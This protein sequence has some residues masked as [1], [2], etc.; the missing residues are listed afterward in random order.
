MNHKYTVMK[1]IT[2]RSCICGMPM[3]RLHERRKIDGKWTYIHV[4]WYC[5]ICHSVTLLYDERS[6]SCDGFKT[7]RLVVTQGKVMQAIPKEHTTK[8]NKGE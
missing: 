5:P 4:A 1:R 6:D 7:I 8:A 3:V 2:A